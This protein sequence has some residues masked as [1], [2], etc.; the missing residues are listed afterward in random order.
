M[1]SHSTHEGMHTMTVSQA[2]SDTTD[3]TSEDYSD[4]YYTT[5]AG[6][7][8]YD[9]DNDGWRDFFMQAA[10]RIRA[11]TN[12]TTSL[13]VGCA[14][15]LFVQALATV[16]LDAT[17]FDISEAAI[18]AAHPDVRGR[19]RVASATEPIEGRYSLISC[20]EVLEHLDPVSAEKAIDHI[21]EATDLVLFTSTPGHFDE[22]THVNVRPT[23]DWVA[24]FA[25][26]GFFRR[27]DV[28]L[29][30]LAPWGVLLQ[31]ADMQPRD[32]A[33][34]YETQ[35][36]AL[37]TEVREKRQALLDSH[38]ELANLHTAGGGRAQGKEIEQ[39]QDRVVASA[40]SERDARLARVAAERDLLTT[41]DHIIGLEARINQLNQRG[42]GNK[43]RM[44][45]EKA[46][47]EDLAKQLR[48]QCRSTQDARRQVEELLSSRTWQ[49]GQKV[50]KMSG[51]LRRLRG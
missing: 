5:Y 34:R 13:D 6:H 21:C 32:V 22:P 20:I 42:S 10:V 18:A 36:S 23:A 33:H 1:L 40:E 16:G 7:G 47:G 48:E 41:R 15:G 8:D 49:L 28:Q 44:D 39:L 35:Y 50:A 3:T 14:K 19:V 30:F 38:R 25:E 43:G 37:S 9:W 24:S 46:K 26:R 51:P 17:G 31:R 2:G 27:T 4:A 11:I 45:K 12:A 29:D